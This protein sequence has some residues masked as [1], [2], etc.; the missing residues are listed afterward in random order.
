[1][2]DT[3][4]AYKEPGI[5]TR[6]RKEN[7]SKFKH[8]LNDHQNTYNSL[9]VWFLSQTMFVR[10][11]NAFTLSLLLW[12]LPVRLFYKPLSQV[13]VS[14]DE[15]LDLNSKWLWNVLKTC[16]L[17]TRFLSPLP[18][19]AVLKLRRLPDR[20]FV[21]DSSLL[22]FVFIFSTKWKRTENDAK[23]QRNL[24]QQRW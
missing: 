1:M 23:S 12:V 21:N 22:L 8:N 10:K 3:P 9:E 4:L 2:N 24:G 11:M 14:A 18:R 13:Q 5:T 7:D 6:K 16:T 15:E 19:S 20:C 17:P